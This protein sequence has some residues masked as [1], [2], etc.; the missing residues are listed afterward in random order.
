M[1][2]V[3]ERLS[4]KLDGISSGHLSGLEKQKMDLHPWSAQNLHRLIRQAPFDH[5]HAEPHRKI[6]SSGRYG[7]RVGVNYL[8]NPVEYLESGKKLNFLLNPNPVE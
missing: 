4:M 6:Q 3:A 2:S 8:T 7:K 1:L 5:Y